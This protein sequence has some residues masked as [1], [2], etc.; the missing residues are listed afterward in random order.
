MTEDRI[1]A[2]RY[3]LLGPVGRGGMGVVWRARDEVLARE[4]A[5]KEVRP[6]SGADPQEAARWYARLEREAWAAARVS[7]RGVVTV[8]DVVTEAGRPWIVMELVRGISLAETLEADG[9]MEPG[10]VAALGERLAEALAAAHAAGVLHRDVK[11][12]NVLIGNDGRVVLTDFGI[13]RYAGATALT[14]TGEL[15]GSPEYLAPERVLGGEVGPA[16]DLWSLGA[17]LYAA[18][19]G[20]SP[21]RRASPP[22]TVWAAVGE[23]PTPARRAGPLA[24]V[25]TG[26]LHKDPGRRLSA[27][28]AAGLLRAVAAERPGG[29]TT[30]GTGGIGSAAGSGSGSGSGSAGASAR[31]GSAHGP[32]GVPLGAG[33]AGIREGLGRLAGP[34][35]APGGRAGGDA[36]RAAAPDWS[37]FDPRAEPFAMAAPG[38]SGGAAG[39][40]DPKGYRAQ[41]RATLRAAGFA[42][43]GLLLLVALVVGGWWALR[44]EAAAG[45]A[46]P[47]PGRGAASG[48]GRSG[49]ADPK[50]AAPGRS[51]RGGAPAEPDPGAGTQTATRVRVT[52]A[53]EP[54]RYEGVCPPGAA[55]PLVAVTLTV[56]RTPALVSYRWVDRDGTALSEPTTLRWGSGDPLARTL[57]R[58]VGGAVTGAGPHTPAAVRLETSTPETAASPWLEVRVVC[59]SGVDPGPDPGGPSAT[60]SSPGGEPG[61][62]P[63][64]EPSASASAP[65]GGP[66]GPGP[67]DPEPRPSTGTGPGPDPT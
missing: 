42:G 38:E 64:P 30:T 14:L 62:P 50:A 12:A 9:P 13:A 16:S 11:P 23:E 18:V 45:S 65:P 35:R 57:S 53:G 24:P 28:A 29:R 54:G 34:A 1:V 55:A 47:G 3:R 56:D 15:V 63:G 20:V 48:E 10:R 43:L 52:A 31:S 44:T 7:H 5:V 60:A 26:L 4:V 6:A 49:T 19:E 21:F 8:Y 25:L 27:S 2:G 46:G 33:G 32:A 51:A 59:G 17:L 22:E 36:G 67:G 37:G 66:G 61:T 41:E 40:P 39:D 58:A